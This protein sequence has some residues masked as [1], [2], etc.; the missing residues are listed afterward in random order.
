MGRKFSYRIYG[1]NI[2]SDIECPEVV[3]LQDENMTYD[4]VI[5]LGKIN[6]EIHELI[7]AASINDFEMKAE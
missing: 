3:H 4:V 7:V 6:E 5:E 1:L 2:L